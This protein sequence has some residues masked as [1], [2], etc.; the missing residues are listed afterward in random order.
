MKHGKIIFASIF[1]NALE[2][3]DF[4]LYG[5]F[6]FIIAE[7]YFPAA[8]PTTAVLQSLGVFAVGFVMRPFGAAVFGYIGD[9]F[10][11]RRALTLSILL[12]GIPTFVIGALPSYATIG[13]AAP[14][15]IILCRLLQ[16]LCTGGEYN[17]AAIFALEHVGKNSP[18]LTG[19]LITMSAGVGAMLAMG[20][21]MI[22]CQ[23]CMP[24][25]GWRA[26][27]LVG[28]IASFWGWYVR[29]NMAESPAFQ[30]MQ[31]EHKIVK[32]PLKDAL[33]NHK[34]AVFVT[35]VFGAFDGVL[36]YIVFVFIYIFLE[37]HMQMD[38]M[39]AKALTFLSILVFTVGSPIMGHFLDRFNGRKF[40]LL[41][42][43]LIGLAVLPTFWLLQYGTWITVIA[44]SIL[45]G[46]M[47]SSI[48]GAQHAFVQRLFP[49]KDRYSGIA[50]SFSV[51]M[52][53]GGLTPFVLT[54]ILE[55]TNNYIFLGLYVI[56]WSIVCFYAVSL[57]KRLEKNAYL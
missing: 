52:S 25:W 24:S 47:A 18:G 9:K 34:L 17:G 5:A 7:T 44:A 15:I 31:S 16:G 48:A 40:L 2:F 19:G 29:T 12:M 32:A 11:R 42:T 49:T 55:E 1:G 39:M 36:S 46:L 43:V 33:V 30:K 3:Y 41:C 50:F 54:K 37:L 51:G 22:A 10:G 4:T 6:A 27:F 20:I 8:S 14:V 45:F 28:T 35:M 38:G 57:A 23:E 56:A 21:S 13:W 53:I 26:A